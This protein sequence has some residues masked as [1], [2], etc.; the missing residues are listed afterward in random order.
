M[1][2]EPVHPGIKTNELKKGA[3]VI[4]RNGWEARLEDNKKGQVRLATVWGYETE[5]GS[6][7]AHDIA[8]AVVDGQRVAV[9]HTEPQLNLRDTLERL[10]AA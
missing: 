3:L 1:A 7:Y 9:T 6:I 8:Y 4:L 2:W 10:R 5:M